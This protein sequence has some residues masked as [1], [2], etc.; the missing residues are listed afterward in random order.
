MPVGHRR[1]RGWVEPPHLWLGV[2]GEPGTGKSPGAD[3][4][5]RDVLP[6]IERRMLADFPDRLWA[7]RTDV[8]L[9]KVAKQRWRHELRDP[10]TPG[11]AITPA[12]VLV[13]S[14]LE[15]QMP[16][17]RQHDV[18]VEKVAE[19]LARAAPKGLLI[20]RDE[21]AG[22][23]AGMNS[24]NSGAR[25]FW[26]E[27]YGGRPYR[28]E[29]KTDPDP[30]VVPHLAVAVYGGTQPDKL[31]R[32]LREGDDGLLARLLW[33]WPEQIPFRLGEQPPRVEWAIDALDRLRE[34]DLQRDD[35][36]RPILVPLAVEA[37]GS[38]E[39]LARDMQR[40]QQD[41]APLLRSALGKARGQA[42]RLSL[43]LE[44]LW[45]CAEQGVLP[46]PI[47]IGPRAF[48][49]AEV[50]MTEYFIPMAAR[51]YGEAQPTTEHRN[52]AVLA[53]WIVRSWPEELHPRQ[54]QREVRL[55][56]LHTAEQIRGAA[57]ALVASGWLRSPH[58]PT[59]FGPRTRVSYRINPR[60]RSQNAWV[61]S[62]SSPDRCRTAQPQ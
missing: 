13:T 11:A 54:L 51:A 22:W 18:T 28:V 20:V 24:F 61:G 59:R 2:V 35:P 38:L 8:A 41:A 46:P 42:L 45:W 16:R 4:L 23:I 15:P 48:A 43:V 6:E 34:L 26:I 30:I 56:G 25:A 39:R 1:H 29:R 50:L 62:C 32:L 52:A 55:P 10:T 40:R 36:P 31:A 19:L 44:F 58:R 21:L 14:P 60:L 17:L 12:P 49:A 7:W 9:S 5:M 57:E 3:A 47:R 33:M 27:A 53:R 37:R